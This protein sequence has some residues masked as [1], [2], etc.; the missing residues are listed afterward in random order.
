MRALGAAVWA[1]TMLTPWIPRALASRAWPKLVALMSLRMRVAANAT[2]AT[3]VA[4][5]ARAPRTLVAG[6]LS[7]Q[8]LLARPVA[9]TLTLESGN[10]VRAPGTLVWSR[11]YT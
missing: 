11:G 3:A 9:A 10:A 4:A 8:A 7:R 2:A 5:A 6:A 1:R